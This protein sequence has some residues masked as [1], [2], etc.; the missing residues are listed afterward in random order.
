MLHDMLTPLTK[1]PGSSGLLFAYLLPRA[2]SNQ[3]IDQTTY[4]SSYE[5]N[6]IYKDVINKRCSLYVPMHE[7]YIVSYSP[8]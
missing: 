4:A 5:N 3:S 1:C 2:I 8:R 6:V 7:N